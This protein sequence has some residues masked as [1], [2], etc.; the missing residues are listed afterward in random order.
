MNKT[1]FYNKTM[2]PNLDEK[3]TVIK[4]LEKHL[5]P[6]FNSIP[7]EIAGKN[8]RRGKLLVFLYSNALI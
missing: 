4:A 3:Y 2:V 1:P 5:L 8:L 6:D 7:T